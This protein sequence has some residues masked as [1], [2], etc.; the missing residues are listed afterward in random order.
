LD[1]LNP[2][3]PPNATRQF[4]PFGQALTTAHR[5]RVISKT[6]GGCATAKFFVPA[7]PLGLP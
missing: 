7:D 4:K 2:V 3:K 1:R 5:Q 6:H